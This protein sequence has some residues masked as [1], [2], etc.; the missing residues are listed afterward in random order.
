MIRTLALISALG[1]MLGV[2]SQAPAL[3]RMGDD[4]G[5]D[6]NP[7]VAGWSRDSNDALLFERLDRSKRERATA[8]ERPGTRNARP[9]R[10]RTDE[11]AK[12][13]QHGRFSGLRGGIHQSGIA[14]YYWQ[15]QRLAA[16]G[17]FNPNAMTAAHKTLP[18]GTKVRVK[19]AGTGRSVEV[20]INDRGPYG[21]GRV[22]DLSSA[23][24]GAI[25][26]KS[27]GL[28]KVEIEVLGR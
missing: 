13:G 28:A 10:A 19:H 21:A 23:A 14:S 18:F 2:A 12:G 25:G 6:G 11:Q 1:L 3:A 15:P 8:D 26:L 9:T 4:I 16:G 24:A 17:W 7:A 22:I 5:F 27:A 20:T